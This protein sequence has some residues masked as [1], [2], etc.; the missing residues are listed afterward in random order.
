LFEKGEA[1]KAYKIIRNL[2]VVLSDHELLNLSKKLA[3]NSEKL[4]YIENK[5]KEVNS[6]FAAEITCA[7][8][9]I[10]RISGFISTGVQHKDVECEALIDQKHQI[11]KIVRL[12]TGECIDE[13]Q[14]TNSDMQLELNFEK[15]QS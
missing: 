14:L 10:D 12:D 13:S 1:M 11:K 5:K 8:S 15:E 4:R 7:K 6:G 3:S 9:Q 2:P